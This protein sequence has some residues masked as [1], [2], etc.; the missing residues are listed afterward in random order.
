MAPRENKKKKKRGLQGKT[1]HPLI[2]HDGL[3]RINFLTFQREL[4]SSRK[5]RSAWNDDDAVPWKLS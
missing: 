4:V 2:F 3:G 1:R 5:E